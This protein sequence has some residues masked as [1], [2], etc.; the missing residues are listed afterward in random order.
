M[1]YRNTK[2]KRRYGS[3]LRLELRLARA[4]RR[5]TVTQRRFIFITAARVSLEIALPQRLNRGLH[6]DTEVGAAVVEIGRILW[7]AQNE[8]NKNYPLTERLQISLADSYTELLA[9][10]KLQP[11]AR[12]I[13]GC[14]WRWSVRGRRVRQ[15]AIVGGEKRLPGCFRAFEVASEGGTKK[16]TLAKTPN[17]VSFHARKGAIH[18]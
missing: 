6:L 9:E 3:T 2:K 12:E 17:K 15:T 11:A 4:C 16:K 1:F 14:S 18:T 13:Q 8:A 10:K 5:P 7:G